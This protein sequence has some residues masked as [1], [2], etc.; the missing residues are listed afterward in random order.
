MM[1]SFLFFSE[2]TEQAW[3]LGSAVII[4]ALVLHAAA[5]PYEDHRVDWCEFFSL[6][7]TLFLC[8]AGVV[9]KVVNDPE[10]PD[11]TASGLFL[12]SVLETVSMALVFLNAFASFYVE[13]RM[14]RIIHVHFCWC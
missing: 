1:A 8:Q 12:A 2:S 13:V 14:Y 11:T 5:R 7:S 3:F 6:V 9:F 4:V 10:H